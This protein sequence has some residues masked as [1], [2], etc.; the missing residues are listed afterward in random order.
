MIVEMAPGLY[1]PVDVPGD[2]VDNS[3]FNHDNAHRAY[4][5]LALLGIAAHGLLNLKLSP[6]LLLR[7][8][9]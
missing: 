2:S 1:T 3:W 9:D 5:G 7:V 6:T 4:P 8:R